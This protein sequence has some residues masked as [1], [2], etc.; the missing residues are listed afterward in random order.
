MESFFPSIFCNPLLCLLL[1]SLLL[2]QASNRVERNWMTLS[3]H[4]GQREMLMSSSESTEK[5]ETSSCLMFTRLIASYMHSSH[6]HKHLFSLTFPPPHL[7]HAHAYAIHTY[8]HIHRIPPFTI[9]SLSTH[10]HTHTHT[11]FLTTILGSGVWLCICSPA[12]MDRPHL[13]MQAD[14]TRSSG[15]TQCLPPSLLW[16]SSWYACL[17]I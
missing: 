11:P 7:W 10:P 4:P 16:R 2:T 9:L 14:R 6:D 1:L 3:S 15:S 17:Y 8:V 12:W 5:C 13:W